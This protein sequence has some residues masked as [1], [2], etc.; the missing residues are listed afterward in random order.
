MSES[1]KS[2]CNKSIYMYIYMYIYS[3][4]YIYMYIHVPVERAVAKPECRHVKIVFLLVNP[5]AF[6]SGGTV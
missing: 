5:T 6:V 2:L 4:I 1:G 3:Y